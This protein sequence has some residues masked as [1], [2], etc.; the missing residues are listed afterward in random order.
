[1]NEV[2]YESGALKVTRT[3]FRTPRRSYRIANIEKIN[4]KRPMLWFSLPLSA[5]AFFLLKEYGQ[6]LYEFE[7]I[8]CLVSMVGLPL[9][10]A[11]VGTLSVSSKALGSDDA[12]I[13]SIRTLKRVRDALETV[14][15]SNTTNHNN[16]YEDVSHD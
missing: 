3:L 5:G 8:T 15:F 6:Y 1:M 2:I 16:D 4:L 7:Q 11:Q 14:M 9:I 12:V 13:G 10:G